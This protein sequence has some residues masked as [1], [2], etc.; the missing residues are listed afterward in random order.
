MPISRAENFHRNSPSSAYFCAHSK[1][2]KIMEFTWKSY[3]AWWRRRRERKNY[4][5][6]QLKR[7]TGLSV[8]KV[9]SIHIAKPKPKQKQQLRSRIHLNRSRE[10]FLESVCKRFCMW[11]YL[12]LSLSLDFGWAARCWPI[13]YLQYELDNNKSIV[14]I[15]L[16]E[17]IKWLLLLSDKSR[18]SIDIHVAYASKMHRFV[19]LWMKSVKHFLWLYV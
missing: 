3:G 6:Q 12:S 9:A 19:L 10:S 5:Q 15:G 7:K 2:K 17:W 4:G 18:Q 1:R 16:F 13:Y 8:L 11:I 14:F